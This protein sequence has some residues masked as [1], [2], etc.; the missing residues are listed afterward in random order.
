MKRFPWLY[1]VSASVVTA[2][3][4][5][6]C[7]AGVELMQRLQPGYPGLVTV[8]RYTPP[9]LY[10]SAHTTLGPIPLAVIYFV[11]LGFAW[12]RPAQRRAIAFVH[13]AL[14]AAVVAVDGLALHWAVKVLGQVP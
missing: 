14:L 8:G 13:L 11:A 4:I 7:L 5:A 12:R 3:A 1:A 6:L 2:G 9:V 10:H